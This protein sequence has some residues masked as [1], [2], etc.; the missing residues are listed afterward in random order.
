M[1]MVINDGGGG[2]VLQRRHDGG[3]T[4]VRCGRERSFG[5]VMVVIW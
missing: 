3:A 5:Y 2:A 1:K 4:M